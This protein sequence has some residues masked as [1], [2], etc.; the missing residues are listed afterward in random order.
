MTDPL[1]AALADARRRKEQAAAE[2]RLL[3][4][5]A[6]GI[7]TRQIFPPRGSGVVLVIL[8]SASARLFTRAVCPKDDSTRIGREV[9]S[10]SSVARL[11]FTPAGRMLS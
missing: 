3:L 5:Y 2:M 11:V 9:F 7:T 6:R 10:T 8:A 1:L 4:A